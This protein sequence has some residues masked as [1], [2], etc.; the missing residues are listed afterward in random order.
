LSRKID[1]RRKLEGDWRAW[2]EDRQAATVAGRDES[3]TGKLAGD[4][5]RKLAGRLGR[6]V[7]SRRKLENGPEDLLKDLTVDEGLEV[8]VGRQSR[9][10]IEDASRRSIGRRG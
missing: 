1:G 2:L 3:G 6:K 10:W 5:S 7:G 4:A 9:R 8:E